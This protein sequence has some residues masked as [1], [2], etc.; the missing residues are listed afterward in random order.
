MNLLSILQ[1]AAALKSLIPQPDAK[2]GIQS[3]EFWL[4]GII[5]TWAA[6]SPSVP[7][8]YNIIIPAAAVGVYTVAR[9]LV[10]V[11]HAFNRLQSIPE[12]PALS[13]QQD[14]T[15]R[16]PVADATAKPAS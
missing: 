9:G 4:T 14:A 3:T 7:A 1:A 5:S 11:A 16:A 13:A 12:L 2:P 15:A 10:K 8:P 6:L